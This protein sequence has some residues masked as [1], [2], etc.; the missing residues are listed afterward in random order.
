MEWCIIIT[1]ELEKY[2][3]SIPS[4]MH[5]FV[6]RNTWKEKKLKYSNQN[7]IVLSYVG[8]VQTNDMNWETDFLLVVSVEIGQGVMF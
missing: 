5:F 2:L 1:V 3:C 6:Y 4:L 8:S 7:Y